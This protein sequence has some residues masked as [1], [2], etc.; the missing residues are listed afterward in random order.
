[1]SKSIK[2]L[3]SLLLLIFRNKEVEIDTDLVSDCGAESTS[4]ITAPEG[5]SSHT[6]PQ[7]GLDKEDQSQIITNTED[8]QVK[9]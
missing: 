5:E 1:M 8:T 3:N 6:G 9:I 4:H 7:Q 2:N